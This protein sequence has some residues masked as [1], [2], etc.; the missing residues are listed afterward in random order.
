MIQEFI[1]NVLVSHSFVS[2][3]T[4]LIISKRKNEKHFK[5]SLLKI[6]DCWLK[7]YENKTKAQGGAFLGMLLG[8]LT[9]S[10]LGNML[11]SKEEI[12]AGNGVIRAGQCF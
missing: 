7:Q 4:T 8:T 5:K 1:K 6:L 10:L 9:A 2:G 11:G 12:I 3:T